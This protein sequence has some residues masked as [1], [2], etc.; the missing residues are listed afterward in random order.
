VADEIVVELV[1]ERRAD[2]VRR[3]DHEKRMAVGR[4]PH[5]RFSANIAATSRPV[6]NDELLTESLR[7][8][9]THQARNDVGRT[10]CCDGDDQTHGP[11]R[12]ALRR[13]DARCDR[14]SGSTRCKMQKLTTRELC[15][16]DREWMATQPGPDTTLRAF[17]FRHYRRG[18][19]FGLAMVAIAHES[20][21]RAAAGAVL[22]HHPLSAPAG[23]VP[24]PHTPEPRRRAAFP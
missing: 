4:R 2:R 12:I 15:C 18:L 11:P 14:E 9:L 3:V 13:C 23:R 7:Q 21:L 10:A 20:L 24:P 1:I 17:D 16:F 8:P 6:I 5:D 22:F 19:N